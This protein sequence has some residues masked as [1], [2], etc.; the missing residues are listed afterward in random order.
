MYIVKVTLTSARYNCYVVNC[1][2]STFTILSTLFS[3][4]CFIVATIYVCIY[5]YI[6]M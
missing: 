2:S 1:Y 5:I 4:N 6:H 3:L